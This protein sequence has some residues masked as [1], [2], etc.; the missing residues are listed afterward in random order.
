MGAIQRRQIYEVSVYECYP[1]GRLNSWTDVVVADSIR[2][3]RRLAVQALESDGLINRHK[4]YKTSVF[5]T[6]Q[7]VAV[8]V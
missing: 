6:G 1:S 7:R 2:E 5:E 4:I 8:G 3:A